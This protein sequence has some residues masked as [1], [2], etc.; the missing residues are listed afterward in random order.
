MSAG[1]ASEGRPYPVCIPPWSRLKS[2]CKDV[3]AANSK[4]QAN[5]SL[6]SGLL[7]S[8]LTLPSLPH[9]AYSGF[10]ETPL[11]LCHLPAPV[12]GW[13]SVTSRRSPFALP[14]PGDLAGPGTACYSGRLAITPP[15]PIPLPWLLPTSAT[16]R[17]S[18]FQAS[19]PWLMLLPHPE[20]LSC[21]LPFANSYVHLK[22]QFTHHLFQEAFPG[23]WTTLPAWF[24]FYPSV[25]S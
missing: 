18:L 6:L 24:L 12:L 25:T 8:A 10:P 14:S 1:Q 5:T 20:P 4:T 22:I 13:S 21:F 7:A 2:N 15:A 16:C 3:P 9:T 23:G 19:R 17:A 11:W